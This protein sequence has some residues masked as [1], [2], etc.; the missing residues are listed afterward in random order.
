VSC[1][2][3]F[4]VTCLLPVA[5]LMEADAAPARGGKLLCQQQQQQHCQCMHSSSAAAVEMFAAA[6]AAASAAVAVA[7]DGRLRQQSIGCLLL[8]MPLC[9]SQ[10][11]LK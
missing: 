7:S 9:P 8:P 10:L 6:V 11:L 3:P 5:A 1:K 4:P 2:Q